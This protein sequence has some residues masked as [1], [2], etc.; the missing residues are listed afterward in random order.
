MTDI[1]I[2]DRAA[3]EQRRPE[4]PAPLL[5][6]TP[7]EIVQNAS[8][9]ATVLASV[10]EA[11]QMYA[12]IQGK[13]HVTVEGWQTVGMMV[14]L[15][16]RTEWCRRMEDR[17]GWEARAQVVRMADGMIV[18]ADESQCDRTESRWR[19]ADDFAIR[20]MA[21]T[22]A[23]SK[24]FRGVLAFVVTMAGYAATPAEEMPDSFSTPSPRPQPRPTPT[25]MNR[26]DRVVTEAQVKLIFGK[27]KGAG[28]LGDDGKVDEV[29]LRR[30]VRAKT[31]AE[32][33][34]DVR[35]DQLDGLLETIELAGQDVEGTLE[36]LSEWESKNLGVAS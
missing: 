24:A 33:F 13:K 15:T 36:S 12:T 6:A 2:Y 25:P 17:D 20:S 3:L 11:Q 7:Q 26:P 23:K 14:G 28:L 19:T 32:H 18:G 4:P 30:I 31:K 1:E 5:G 16:A 34:N 29:L 27:A 8:A 9:M 10:I 35:Q 21:Q 22:R